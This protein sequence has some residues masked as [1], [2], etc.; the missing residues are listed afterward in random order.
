MA[1]AVHARY[2]LPTARGEPLGCP[3]HGV[4]P[5][6]NATFWKEKISSNI[7]RDRE[8]DHTLTLAG[9]RVI[10]VWE[11]EDPEAA[12]AR[13]EMTV[14][15]VAPSAGHA[16]PGDGIRRRGRLE[17]SKGVA[18]ANGLEDHS[19]RLQLFLR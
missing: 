14:R 11:H 17:G 15:G 10:R 18:C 4:A 8:T 13:I 6:A 3:E 19:Q 2:A 9:F 7:A 5:K 16:Q 1:R 12:A